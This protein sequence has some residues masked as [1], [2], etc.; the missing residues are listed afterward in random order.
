MTSKESPEPEYVDSFNNKDSPS[1]PFST[2]SRVSDRGV[3]GTYHSVFRRRWG[4]HWIR[5]FIAVL[6]YRDRQT[7]TLT[8]TPTDSFDW[9]INFLS[10]YTALSLLTWNLY[11]NFIIIHT[12]RTLKPWFFLKI[13][14]IFNAAINNIRLILKILKID[15]CLWNYSIRKCSTSIIRFYYH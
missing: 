9:P 15:L 13:S 3:A 8:F 4:S 6:T 14:V 1:L 2:T 10:K 12:S 11:L 5:Q 7:F